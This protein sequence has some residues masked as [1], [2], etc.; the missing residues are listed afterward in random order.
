MEF[1]GTIP[2]AQRRTVPY[3]PDF[4]FDG[5]SDYYGTSLAALE[6][7][8]TAKG[9]TLVHQ[10]HALNAFFIRTDLLP[11]N[12]RPVVRYTPHQYHRRDPHDRPWQ[13]IVDNA[14]AFCGD[15]FAAK[16]VTD[17]CRRYSIATVIEGGTYHGESTPFLS[18]LADRVYTIEIDDEVWPR[19]QHLDGIWNVTRVKGSSPVELRKLLRVVATPVL[20]YADSHWGV[21]SPLPDELLAFAEHGVRPVLIMRD[22]RNPNHPELGFDTYGGQSYEWEWIQPYIEAIYGG[23]Y[24]HY[25]N[26][27]AGGARRGILYVVPEG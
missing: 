23:R 11:T 14:R 17:L 25:F 7:L 24:R 3:D 16:E 21:P 6:G 5:K 12:A 13:T 4:R 22:F 20:Y 15:Q 26:E 18:A 27:V 10:L 19:S 9:Y 1:N 2:E 8:C